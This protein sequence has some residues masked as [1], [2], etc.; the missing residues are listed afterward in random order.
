MAAIL[1]SYMSQNLTQKHLMR[2]TQLLS[3]QQCVVHPGNKRPGQL[4]QRHQTDILVT[5]LPT[6]EELAKDVLDA[7]RQRPTQPRQIFFC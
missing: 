4:M 5:N 6:L 1:V 3:I 7:I 2:L